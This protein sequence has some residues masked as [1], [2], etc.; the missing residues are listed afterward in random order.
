MI[1][2]AM[3]HGFA[4]RCTCAPVEYLIGQSRGGKRVRGVPTDTST[5]GPGAKAC[6]QR[7]PAGR[8]LGAQMTQPTTDPVIDQWLSDITRAA[9][10]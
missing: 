2:L 1:K 5:W 4:A 7:G 3:K 9:D 8:P 6:L 10:W